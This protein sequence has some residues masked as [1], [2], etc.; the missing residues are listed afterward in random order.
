M[1]VIIRKKDN[2]MVIDFS[3]YTIAS[4]ELTSGDYIIYYSLEGT[5]YTGT[6]A[7][8]DYVMYIVPNISDED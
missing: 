7:E 3:A 4:A 8:T 5:S 2:S 6:Y 1:N